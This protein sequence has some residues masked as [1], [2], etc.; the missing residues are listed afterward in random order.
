MLDANI[1][2]ASTGSSP[3]WVGLEGSRGRKLLRRRGT[4]A[5][6]HLEVLGKQTRALVGPA[7]HRPE[8]EGFSSEGQA[9]IKVGIRR[10]RDSLA[11]RSVTRMFQQRVALADKAPRLLDDAYRCSQKQF[12][13]S[14]H[15]LERFLLGDNMHV[16][17]N[18]GTDQRLLFMPH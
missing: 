7:L 4:R 18:S 6:T 13:S 11:M 15:L 1:D 5:G 3:R 16:E 9:V 17:G 12:R 2:R 14:V 10:A 8:R